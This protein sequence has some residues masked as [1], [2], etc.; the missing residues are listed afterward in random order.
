MRSARLLS[1]KNVDCEQL[2]AI[3]AFVRQCDAAQ[4]PVNF[5]K[6]CQGKRQ[7]LNP[8]TTNLLSPNTSS[9]LI[10][11]KAPDLLLCAHDVQDVGSFLLVIEA[12]I[13]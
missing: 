12:G 1:G 6:Y 13:P 7:D 2:D 5:V 9:S 8:D 11:D 4:P 3:M 10:E